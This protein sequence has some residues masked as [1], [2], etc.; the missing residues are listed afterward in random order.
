MKKLMYLLIVLM[1]VLTGCTSSDSFESSEPAQPSQ[2]VAEAPKETPQEAPTPAEEPSDELII[3]PDEI[4]WDIV[5]LPPDSIGTVYMEATY[6]NNSNY[7]ILGYDM[8]VHLKD[9]NE[10]TYLSTYDTVMPGE[11]SAKFESFGPE[12]MDLNDI[13]VLTLDIKARLP[14]NNDMYIEYDFKLDWAEWW[15]SEN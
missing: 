15:E 14:N 6:T 10:T 2:P 1:L 4:P 5:I 9:S 8:E 7:P 3:Y 11:T 12:T 13:E